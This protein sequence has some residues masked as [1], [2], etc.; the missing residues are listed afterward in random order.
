MTAKSIAIG[1]LIFVCGGLAGYSLT[2][3]QDIARLER[4]IAI[5]SLSAEA[6]NKKI[7]AIAPYFR[8]DDAAFESA[9]ID[10]ASLPVAV[11]STDIFNLLKA[12]MSRNRIALGHVSLN[13]IDVSR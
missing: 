4:N 9:W 10:E 7:G 8:R 13:R 12:D 11:F 5:A 1:F 6:A 3:M 2:L